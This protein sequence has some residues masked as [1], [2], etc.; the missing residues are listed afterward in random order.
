M[1]NKLQGAFSR[2]SGTHTWEAKASQ[3]NRSAA[4]NLF[5]K[6]L[7]SWKTGRRVTTVAEAHPEESTPR[8]RCAVLILVRHMWYQ[9]THDSRCPPLR[10]HWNLRPSGMFDGTRGMQSTI[11]SRVHA[12]ESCIETSSSLRKGTRGD[13]ELKPLPQNR[14]PG[15]Q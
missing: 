15:A 11:R 10:S 13:V 3:K 9:E 7:T 1:T 2:N 6:L 4:Y 8:G 12:N 14:K 5:A